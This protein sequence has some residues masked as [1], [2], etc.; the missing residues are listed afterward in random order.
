MLSHYRLDPSSFSITT[1]DGGPAIAYALP[2]AGP[3]DAGHMLPLAPIRIEEPVWWR[4][5]ASS[6]PV[7]SVDG[8]RDVW[9]HGSYEV[10]VRYEA[11]GDARLSLRD[12][13]SRE[14]PVGRVS[15]PATRIYWLDRPGLDAETRRAL[16]R[17]FQEAAS[18]GEGSA[19][20]DAGRTFRPQLAHN[21]R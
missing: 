12:S 19:I 15:A 11:S 16:G 7:A 9:R 20:A 13:T 8:A 18:Y 17:A 10:V 2:G 14:W 1:V 21:I 5:A 4:D 6:L 3:G